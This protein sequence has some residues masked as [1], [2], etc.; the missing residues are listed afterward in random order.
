M[1]PHARLDNVQNHDHGS[2]RR[3]L[4]PRLGRFL[5]PLLPGGYLRPSSISE[6]AGVLLI[7]KHSLRAPA[8]GY[9]AR[10]SGLLGRTGFLLFRSLHE[11]LHDAQPLIS[12]LATWAEAEG[13]TF[14]A[15]VTNPPAMVSVYCGGAS[16]TFNRR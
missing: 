5:G 14:S 4:E 3:Q 7:D 13:L 10:S 12:L 6:R 11:S 1:S 8:G 16:L 15:T 9:C 2:T